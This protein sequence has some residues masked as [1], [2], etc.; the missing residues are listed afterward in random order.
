VKDMKLKKGEIIA[1]HCGLVPFK[2]WSDKKVVTVILTYH[3]HDTRTVTIRGKETVKPISVLDY[4][5]CMGG[6]DLKDQL[7]HSYL[8]ERKIMNKWCMK[9]FRRFLNTSILNALIIYRNNTGKGADQ[10]SFRMQLVEGL[11]VKYANVLE[12]KVPGQ[13]SSNNTVPRLTERHF[14]SK[15]LPSEKK[16]RLQRRC[17]LCQKRGKRKETVYWCNTCD[18]GCCVECF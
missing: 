1:Q 9:L 2:K 10:L 3:S 13:H 4:I 16:T 12:H 6:V 15:I 17:V 7:L 18:V 8:I 11:F 14:I 5:Q